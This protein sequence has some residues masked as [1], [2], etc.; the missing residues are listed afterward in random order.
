MVSDF[1]F[2][3]KLA[4]DIAG[5]DPALYNKIVADNQ[6]PCAPSTAPGK[7]R[8][9]TEDDVIV[10]YI[11]KKELDSGRVARAAGFIA[12]EYKAGMSQHPEEE[13][14]VLVYGRYGDW[15]L[16]PGSTYDPT[17]AYCRETEG[18]HYKGLSPVSME[19]RHNIG[20]I[21]KR[22]ADRVRHEQRILGAPEDE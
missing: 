10:A 18:A 14:L 6:L 3:P 21:R 8:P 15:H 20:E 19:I 11:L 2:R 12:C 22:I 5:I 9:F 13:F 4:L 7:A 17:M 1:L 16:F